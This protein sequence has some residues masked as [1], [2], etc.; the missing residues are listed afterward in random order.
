MREITKALGAF[1]LVAVVAFGGL[2]ALRLS[3][4]DEQLA[5]I[6]DEVSGLAMTPGSPTDAI[7]QIESEIG[8][9]R[10]VM[11]Q[12]HAFTHAVPDEHDQSIRLIV[13]MQQRLESFELSTGQ[14]LD[15]LEASLSHICDALTC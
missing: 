13:S 8:A 11:L 9:L 3:A 1:T 15:E 6:S 2:I 7:Y 14:R 10:D 12:V 5:S 4:I